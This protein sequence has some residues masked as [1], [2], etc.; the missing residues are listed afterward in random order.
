MVQQGAVQWWVRAVALAPWHSA[1]ALRLLVLLWLALT[2]PRSLAWRLVLRPQACR[3]SGPPVSAAWQELSQ[4]V[5]GR[6]L[7]RVQVALAGRALVALCLQLPE[8]ALLVH[9]AAR[10]RHSTRSRLA[11]L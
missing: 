11:A 4:Q 6:D 1:V 5:A 8:R 7:L 2:A 3:F 9:Q 10:R